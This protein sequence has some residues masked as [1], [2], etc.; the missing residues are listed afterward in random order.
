MAIE[1]GSPTLTVI[2]TRM[3]RLFITVFLLSLTPW[4]FA[5]SV[6]PYKGAET[7]DTAAQRAMLI[8]T[9][10][11]EATVTG[12]G[13]R[14]WT[15]HRNPDGTYRVDFTLTN[16]PNLPPTYS[17]TGIWGVSGGILFTATRGFVRP[18][19]RIVPAQTNDPSLYDTYRILK[20][21]A[22][23]FEY[24]SLFNGERFVTRRVPEPGSKRSK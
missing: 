1:F 10:H 15:T 14:A 22:H 16:V 24:Q 9:W 23:E 11:G 5:Q 6:K 7:A 3:F 4:A 12:G 18:G 20:L 13:T 8:G 19:G 17:E 21:S 2:D